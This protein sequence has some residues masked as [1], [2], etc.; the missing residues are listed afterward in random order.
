MTSRMLPSPDQSWAHST[1]SLEDLRIALGRGDITAIEA[2]ILMGRVVGSNTDAEK[3]PIMA[4]PPNRLS[5]LST[6]T[7]I[8]LC[9]DRGERTAK[10][11]KLDFKE[12]EAVQPTLEHIHSV[13]LSS[14][15]KPV[16]VFLNA[17]ILPGPG[18]RSGENY[19][20]SKGFLEACTS[21]LR[22]ESVSN[23]ILSFALSLGYKADYRAKDDH[24]TVQDAEKMA[25]LVRQ[26]E[27]PANVGTRLQ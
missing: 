11:I 9:L 13:L 8:Q 1:N 19:V 16:T 27:L 15:P 5:S 25:S 17:D 20:D 22:K 21:F 4:H 18:C 2:D 14:Q 24:Y 3:E 23:S 6:S 26:C 10:H 12:I 7:F